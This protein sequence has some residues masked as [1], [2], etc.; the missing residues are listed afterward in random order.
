MDEDALAE[1]SEPLYFR[2]YHAKDVEEFLTAVTFKPTVVVTTLYSTVPSAWK[3]AQRCGARLINFVQGFEPYFDS[4][5]PYEQV[6]NTYFLAQTSITTSSWLTEKVKSKALGCDVKQLPLGINKYTFYPPHLRQF[7]GAAKLRIGLVLRASVDKGQFILR[8]LIDLLFSRGSDFSLTVFK[9]DDYPLA[10]PDSQV[11]DFKLVRLPASRSV[12]ADA[13]REVDIFVDASL[14]EGYGLFPLEAMGCGACAVVS[15][16]GGI[17]QY[18]QDGEN[19]RIVLAMNKPEAYLEQLLEL[20]RDRDALLRMREAAV[21]TAQ[22]YDEE[23]CF[24]RYEEFFRGL[25]EHSSHESFGSEGADKH[26]QSEP[27]KIAS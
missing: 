19:G 10:P 9:P 11:S 23:A 17:S 26:H 7:R 16:S 20:H 1:Y 13:L 18:L 8:E 14:H 6:R 24:D 25:L 21:Q 4:G 22:S 5:R 3:F 15:D 27:H 2:P 12:I